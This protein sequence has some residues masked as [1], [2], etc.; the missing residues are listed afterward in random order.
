MKE[1]TTIWEDALKPSLILSLISIIVSVIIYVFELIT[2]G[3]F[4]GLLI[5]IF[6]FILSIII[7]A[8]LIKSYRNEKLKGFISYGK[9]LLFGIIIALY[10]SVILSVYNIVFTKV[11]DPEYE[12][13]ISI[14]IQEKTEEFMIKKGVPDEAIED[15]MKKS[16]EK[17][18][19]NEERGIVKKTLI[20][21]SSN[22]IASAIASLIAAA[23]V[24]KA[25]N[26]Y[27]AAMQNVKEE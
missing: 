17:M 20:N 9:A 7:L 4:A 2:I 12:K 27:E 1:N 5:G 11:I 25:G 24:K 8:F 6:S 16:Q 22:L 3:L 19:K 13:N 23:F 18:K 21:F 26:P 14:K 10:S 15:A